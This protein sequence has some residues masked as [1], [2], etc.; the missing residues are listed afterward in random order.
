MLRE[1]RVADKEE[2]IERINKYIEEI[3]DSPIV[4]QCKYHMSEINLE[5]SIGLDD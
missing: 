3:N 1:I 5:E 2:L 4:C